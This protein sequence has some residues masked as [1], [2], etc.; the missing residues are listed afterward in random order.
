MESLLTDID[1]E[2]IDEAVYDLE[3]GNHLLGRK[4]GIS[5]LLMIDHIYW[6]REHVAELNI[7]NKE[8][9]EYVDA[10]YSPDAFEKY[11]SKYNIECPNNCSE[12]G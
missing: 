8:L 3:T 6:C 1:R 5:V 9:M 11:K 4:T 12:Q 7:M 10:C 2:I